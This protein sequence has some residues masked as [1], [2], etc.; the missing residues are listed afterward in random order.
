MTWTIC[1]NFLFPPKNAPHDVLALICRA[2][3]KENIFEIVDGRTAY[4]GWTEKRVT[5]GRRGMAIFGVGEL[6]MKIK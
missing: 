2:V 6:R 3:S 1:T 4:D 5:D